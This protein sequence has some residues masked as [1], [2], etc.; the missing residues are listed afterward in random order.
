MKSRLSRRYFVNCLAQTGLLTGLIGPGLSLPA[1]AAGRTPLRTEAL[2][3]QL[4]WIKG[5]ACNVLVANDAQGL[6]LIDGGLRAQSP[7]LLA[8]A[9]KHFKARRVHTLINTHWH[10]ENTGSN[11]IL[12]KEGCKIIAHENTRLW[13]STSVRHAPDGPAIAPLSPTARPNATTYR[14]GE[15][16]LGEET[17]RYGYL[18]QAHTDG[19]LYVHF[20]NADVLVTGG[21]VAGNGWS[22]ADWVTGGWIN[23]TAAGQQ[24]LLGIATEKTR[25]VTGHGDKLITRTELEIERQALGKIADQMGRMMRAGAA[26]ADML[27]ANPAKDYVAQF[28][29]ATHFL[30]ESFRSMWPRM[31]PDA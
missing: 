14:N 29:D 4:L 22:T 12:G 25:I 5:A 16:Q 17:V 15:L 27:A 2:S 1:A 8:L 3:D 24:S 9:R 26:P 13:L 23:G 10:P 31:A 30:N 20:K 19:D 18:S 7:A 28:G 11:E 6:L 21:V